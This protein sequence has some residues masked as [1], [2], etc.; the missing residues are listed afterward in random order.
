[1]AIRWM[2]LTRAEQQPPVEAAAGDVEP[3]GE[4]ARIGAQ[5]RPTRGVFETLIAATWIRAG[6]PFGSRIAPCEVNGPRCD[7]PAAR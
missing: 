7:R 2:L 1:M 6:R 5:A 3:A 4:P